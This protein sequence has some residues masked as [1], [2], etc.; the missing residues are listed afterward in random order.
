MKYPYFLLQLPPFVLLLLTVLVFAIF[1]VAGTYFFRKFIKLNYR[2]SHNEIVGYIF[3]VLGG[4]YGLLMGFVVFL[5]WDSLNLAQSNANREGSLAR[6][7]YRDIRYFPDTQ[8]MQP[9]MKSYLAYVHSVVEK[10]YPA[11]EQ[12]Q[13]L[14]TGY[15]KDF[16]DVFRQMEKLDARDPKVE[17][18]FRHLNEL[19]TYRS[20]RQLDASAEIPVEIWIPLLLGAL[21]IMVFAVMFDVES[22]RLHVTLNGL[23][24]AFIGLVIYIILILDHPFTG[25]IKIEPAEYRTIL[26]M[27]NEDAE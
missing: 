22:R 3:A 21:I 15:R 24:G 26:Q 25:K 6:G 5:V 8:K 20:L 14:T 13:P 1:G 9:L 16:N 23:L 19:A 4:F 7:L 17:Q 12:M 27:V 11:M 10:E 18:M 2:R